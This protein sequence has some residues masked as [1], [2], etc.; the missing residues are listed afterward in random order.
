MNFAKSAALEAGEVMRQYFAIGVKHTIKE[1]NTPLTEADS[2]INKLV[3]ESLE[4]TFPEHSLIGEEI[5]R[6]KDSTYMWILDPLD[7]TIAF[8]RGVPISVFSIALVK[9]GEPIL[10][11]VYDPYL[12]RLYH[13][14]KGG[15]AFLNERKIAT[16]KHQDLKN[17]YIAYEGHRGFKNLHFLNELKGLGAYFLSYGCIIYEHMMVATGQLDAAIFPLPNPWDSA[18]AK[19]IVEEAGGVT[20]SLRGKSQR[21]DQE[22]DGF[23]SACNGTFHKKFVDLVSSSV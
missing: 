2:K 13:A 16:S 14:V 6:I 18:S 19:V 4:K 20:S 23:I 17:S 22:V 12:R 8:L 10:G 3:I 5:S 11:V 9:D 1:D 15:G 7:G 21:Y